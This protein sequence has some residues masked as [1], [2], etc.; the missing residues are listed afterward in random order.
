MSRGVDSSAVL[1][2]RPGIFELE[3]AQP[4]ARTQIDAQ[5]T[6]GYRRC[7]S[8]GWRVSVERTRR[9]APLL[10]ERHKNNF[11]QVEV[12]P[13]WESNPALTRQLEVETARCC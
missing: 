2:L 12:V 4:T 1:L 9:L 11:T 8:L 5:E 13:R 6:S 3:K 10:V 7:L